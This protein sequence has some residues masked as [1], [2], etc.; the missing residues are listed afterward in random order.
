MTHRKR[1]AAMLASVLLMMAVTSAA[2]AAEVP[3]YAEID[4]GCP[5]FTGPGYDYAY[6]GAVEEDGTYTIVAEAQDA[7][8]RLWGMLKSGRGWVLLE[9]AGFGGDA[10]PDG[11]LID[12]TMADFSRPD[13]S[14]AW[15]V[16]EQ[17]EYTTWLTFRAND[18]VRSVQLVSFAV[19]DEGLQIDRV[20]YTLPEMNVHTPL[21]AGVVFYGDMTTYGILCTD[22]EGCL[23]CFTVGVSG[24]DGSLVVE[25]CNLIALPVPGNG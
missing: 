4:Y 3:Y 23:R 21:T 19:A 25:E 16:Q 20:L 1:L 22:G 14:A 17:S 11:L 7:D 10:A 24:Y 12:V 8:G 2:C 9:D 15:Y 5:I 6:A 13:E 18:T